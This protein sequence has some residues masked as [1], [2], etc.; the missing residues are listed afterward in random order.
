MRGRRLNRAQCDGRFSREAPP[1]AYYGCRN[2]T[3]QP[4][5]FIISFASRIYFVVHLPRTH[6]RSNSIR[7]RS[8]IATAFRSSVR[9]QPRRP[10][11]VFLIANHQKSSPWGD[12]EL[13]GIH[14]AR[15][16]LG[17][18]AIHFLRPSVTKQAVPIDL[19]C[20]IY[21]HSASPIQPIS[22]LVAPNPLAESAWHDYLYSAS[23]SRPGSSGA[24]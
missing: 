11:R 9:K 6:G 13:R 2:Q 14:I 20:A 7:M 24:V 18:A 8:S 16:P 23:S 3:N 21:I 22:K 1:K 5:A 4:T 12:R 17:E 19:A 15:Y 10:S